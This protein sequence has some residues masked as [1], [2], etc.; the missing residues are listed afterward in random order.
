MQ[1]ASSDIDPL[2]EIDGSPDFDDFDHPGVA[3]TRHSGSMNF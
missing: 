3:E 1:F 2:I